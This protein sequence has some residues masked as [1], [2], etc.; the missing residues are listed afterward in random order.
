MDIGIAETLFVHTNGSCSWKDSNCRAEAGGPL[1]ISPTGLSLHAASPGKP[2][3]KNPILFFENFIYG[4][5]IYILFT[6]TNYP[7]TPSL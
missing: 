3:L 7:Y 6:P 2:L 5:S 1:V 4:Y